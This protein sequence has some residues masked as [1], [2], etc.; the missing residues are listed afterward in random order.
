MEDIILVGFGGHAKS[1]ADCIERQGKY[2][3][4]GYTDVEE[5]TSVYRYLGTDDEL[6][7]IYDS[8]IKKAVITIGYMG[9]GNLRERLYEKI[10]AIGF[11]LPV[12]ID[13]SAIV[14]N[15][16]TIGEGA[17][18]GKSAIINAETCVGKMTIINTKAL[19]EHECKV[20]DFAHVAVAAVLCGNVIVKK[21]AF[22]GAN[23][24]VIQG[25]S[26]EERQLVPAGVTVR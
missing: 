5:C 11:E 23:S 10:K 16:V 13:P 18:V 6:E 1:V 14:S 8:G 26:I 9:K 3:I 4:A 22:V 15:S 21:A 19:I 7:S 2:R 25:R 12:I 20:E 24:T 17:F